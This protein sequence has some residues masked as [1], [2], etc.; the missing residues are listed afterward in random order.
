MSNKELLDSLL[1]HAN[2]KANTASKIMNDEKE[3][4]R[5]HF[6][7]GQYMAFN[8]FYSLLTNIKL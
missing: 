2:D 3:K 8:E 5:K 7:A 4:N 6:Y 1:F